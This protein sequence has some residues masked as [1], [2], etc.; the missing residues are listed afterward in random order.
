MPKKRGPK[1]VHGET[2]KKYAVTLD[3]MSVR[4]ARVLDEVS[5]SAAIRKAIDIAY[6]QYQS[7]SP[8]RSGND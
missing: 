1:P 7:L 2:M 5:M 8:T 6:R 4:K 3:A